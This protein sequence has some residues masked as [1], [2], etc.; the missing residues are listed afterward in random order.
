[1]SRTQEARTDEIALNPETFHRGTDQDILST[2][3]HE[4]CHLWQQ[5]Y[6]KPSRKGY[7]NKEWASK[8]K[9]IG[10][11]PSN[12]GEPGGGETGQQMTH[13]IQ[14]DGPF[15][16]SFARLAAMGYCL[17]WQSTPG[18]KMQSTR[19]SK[20]KYTC[21]TCEQRAWAKPETN[22]LCGDYLARMEPEE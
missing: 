17:N 18:S 4:M 1:V 14:T 12:T 10:L 20:V 16:H 22:L 5:K 11:I 3:A 8:M 21:P 19:P 7:H 2:L 15:A 13:Y 9:K 6:G